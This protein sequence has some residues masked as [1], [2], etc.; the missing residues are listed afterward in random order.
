MSF[1]SWVS[2]TF[3]T[4]AASASHVVD[5]PSVAAGDLL[6]V[7]YNSDTNGNPTDPSGWNILKS[8]G[9]RQAA[10]SRICDGSEGATLTL[11]IS[12]SRSGKTAV[13]KITGA[14]ASQDPEAANQGTTHD[15]PNLSPSWGSRE[16]MWI[17]ADLY[18]NGSVT[19]YPT[20][21]ADNQNDY[22]GT[23][24]AGRIALATRNLKAASENP[25]AFT[26]TGATA[27][28]VLTI[29]VQTGNPAPV[30]ISR[31]VLIG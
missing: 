29:A 4:H 10:W 5:L 26:L 25:G 18:L 20:S 3:K 11:A 12:P 24:G 19:A 13:I 14:H 8:G 15:P 30:R 23:S 1:P 17:A 9:S 6:I 31:G 16:V 27:G 7:L 28:A 21:Y 22:A 2:V